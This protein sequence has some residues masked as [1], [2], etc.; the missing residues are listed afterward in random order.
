MCLQVRSA[1]SGPRQS[2]SSLTLENSSLWWETKGEKNS[3]QSPHQNKTK[4][5]EATVLILG[6]GDQRLGSEGSSSNR[7]K[8]AR[9]PGST[10]GFA[11]LSAKAGA[12]VALP[13][14]VRLKASEWL[15]SIRTRDCI[16]SV[17]LRTKPIY[18]QNVKN[19]SK[20]NLICLQ[21]YTGDA[22]RLMRAST[23]DLPQGSSPLEGESIPSASQSLNRRCIDKRV[24]FD[25]LHPAF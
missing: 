9:T 20:V 17:L 2:D 18:W 4:Y 24:V 8:D 23:H 3:G 5:P 25:L 10:Y 6:G 22:T 16:N 21:N 11:S 14:E 1:S 19:S 13:C 12:G 7:A 15:I